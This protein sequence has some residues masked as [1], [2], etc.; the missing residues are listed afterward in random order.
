MPSV[1]QVCK[2]EEDEEGKEVAL[3][4]SLS[5]ASRLSR[6]EKLTFRPF[7]VWQ[8][9]ESLILKCPTEITPFINSILAVGVE[10]VAYDPVR[11]LL[12]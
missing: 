3:A 12:P 1:L 10:L 5:P 7:G 11:R 9:L 2:N 4:V 8:T 6:N